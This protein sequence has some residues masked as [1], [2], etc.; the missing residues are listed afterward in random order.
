MNSVKVMSIVF[1]FFG[2]AS[3]LAV[4]YTLKPGD[5]KIDNKVY[6]L[7]SGEILQLKK[8]QSL[9]ID[10]WNNDASSSWHLKKAAPNLTLEKSEHSSGGMGYLQMFFFKV[11]RGKGPNAMHFEQKKG[12]KQVAP[13][14]I[15][16]E[17]K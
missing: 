17:V 8:N 12:D 3:T 13:F 16:Y 10:L 15:S 7:K 4:D 2:T 6:A 11:K 1:A 14:S 9:E 5:V